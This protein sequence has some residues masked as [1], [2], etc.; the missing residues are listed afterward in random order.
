[1]KNS[2]I[3]TH[4]DEALEHVSNLVLSLGKGV[5]ENLDLIYTLIDR[6]DKKWGNRVIAGMEDLLAMQKSIRAACYDI[7]V[8]FHPVAGD[9][10]LVIGLARCSE[11]LEESVLQLGTLARRGKIISGQKKGDNAA[12]LQLI[13]MVCTAMRDALTSLEYKDKVQAKTVKKGDK[14]IDKF[15][16]QLIQDVITNGGE[17]FELPLDVDRIFFI[18]AVER[19][20]DDAKGISNAVCFM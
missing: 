6:K 14:A 11:K 1:M 18:R 19:I 2:H 8:R 4:Y 12:L 17:S 7:L 9:L 13:R 16:R 20:G 5:L 10:R 15:H 3:L